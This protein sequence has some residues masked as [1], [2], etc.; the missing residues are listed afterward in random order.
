MRSILLATLAAGWVGCASLAPVLK[1]APQGDTPRLLEAAE[2]FYRSLLERLDSHPAIE[3]VAWA[4]EAPLTGGRSRTALRRAGEQ[5]EASVEAWVNQILSTGYFGTLGIPVIH[6]RAFTRDEIP[7]PGTEGGRAVMLTD[8]LARQLF[9]TSAAAGR[10]VEF[11]QR[12]RTDRYEVVGVTANIRFFGLTG[13]PDPIVF[14]PRGLS[15]GIGGGAII[16]RGAADAASAAA[17]REAVAGLNS[18]VPFEVTTMSSLVQRSRTQ[19]DV[20]TWLIGGLAVVATILSA[21]GVYGLVAFNAAARRR[22]FGIR[23]AHG[24]AVGVIRRLVLRGAL[25]IGAV[26][27]LVGLAASYALVRVLENQL[28][29]VQ[30]FNLLI[31]GAAAV[32]LAAIVGVAA[33]IPAHRASR[34]NPAETLR[35]M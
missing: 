29:G 28:V 4:K 14:D 13:D 16:V 23:A 34:V 8:V 35:A 20:L 17:I 19:W 32:L 12:G 18:A 2:T 15:P 24:A 27:V 7:G 21:V 6:G 33:L 25:V 31:W 1:A 22:E 26:G 3:R 10:F 30:P 5:P 9:G 11:R